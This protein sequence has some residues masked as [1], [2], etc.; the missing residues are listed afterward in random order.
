MAAYCTS[1][2][3]PAFEAAY[4]PLVCMTGRALTRD[5]KVELSTIMDPLIPDFAMAGIWK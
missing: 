2:L 5:P 1:I 4:T 3:A